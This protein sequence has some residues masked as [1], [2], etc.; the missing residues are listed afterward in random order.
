MKMKWG[1][2]V[3]GREGKATLPTCL[4]LGEKRHVL[5]SMSFFFRLGFRK[6]Q[7]AREWYKNVE[8]RLNFG[9]GRRSELANLID[10][11]DKCSW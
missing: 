2:D 5:L 4:E 1:Q 9:G 6:S 3:N 7:T 8:K 10:I 11:F